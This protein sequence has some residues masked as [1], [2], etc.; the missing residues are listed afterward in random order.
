MRVVGFIIGAAL[1]ERERER[2]R[3]S[4]CCG[5]ETSSDRG[6]LIPL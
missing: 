5:R 3:R 1:R 4:R 6:V 2:E